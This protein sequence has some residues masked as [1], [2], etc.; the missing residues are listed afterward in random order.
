[1]SRAMAAMAPVTFTGINLFR[2]SEAILESS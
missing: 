2:R 1:M